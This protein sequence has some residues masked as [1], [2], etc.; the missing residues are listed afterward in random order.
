[1]ASKDDFLKDLLKK[2]VNKAIKDGAPRLVNKP[3]R[4]SAAQRAAK[5]A[6]R[7]P[8]LSSETRQKGTEQLIREW[9]RKL[10]ADQ[11]NKRLANKDSSLLA[12]REKRGNPVTKKQIR[13][14]KGANKGLEKNLP[15]VAGKQSKKSESQLISEAAARRNKMEARKAAGGKNSAENIAKRQQKRAEMRKKNNKKK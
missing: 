15:K 11:V 3:P 12:I 10:K 7:G 6:A 14:A 2:V 5:R 8:S 13:D 1:M 4:P 9:D